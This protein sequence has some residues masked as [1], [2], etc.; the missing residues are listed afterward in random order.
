MGGQLYSCPLA[1]S[2]LQQ[3]PEGKTSCGARFTEGPKLALLAT[4]LWGTRSSEQPCL[5]LQAQLPI[6]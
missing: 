4:Y 2:H 5:T 3:Q 6:Q 1:L